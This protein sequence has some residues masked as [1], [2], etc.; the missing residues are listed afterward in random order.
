MSV[1]ALGTSTDILPG[2]STVERD[3]GAM[4]C[5]GGLIDVSF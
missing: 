5:L 1:I 3:A 2:Y 4:P